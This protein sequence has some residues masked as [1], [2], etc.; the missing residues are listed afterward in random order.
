MREGDYVDSLIDE[1]KILLAQILQK[2]TN[3]KSDESEILRELL[4][5]ADW[6]TPA[7][8]EL[9]RLA[10]HY[11]AFMLRNALAIAVVLAKEDGSAG[12]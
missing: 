7:A 5:S 9:V 8:R 2:N 1:Y 4:V 12:F 3:G 10:E 11:G 6:S